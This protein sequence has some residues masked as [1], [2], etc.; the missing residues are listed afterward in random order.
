MHLTCSRP[1]N[2]ESPRDPVDIMSMR[3]SM[4]FDICSRDWPDSWG[5]LLIMRTMLVLTLPLFRLLLRRPAW[6][7][8][9]SSHMQASHVTGSD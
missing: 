2:S 8:F 7:K 4:S 9:V 6:L 5:L 3:A 1:R